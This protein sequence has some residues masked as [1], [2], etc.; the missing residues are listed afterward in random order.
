MY[1]LWMQGNKRR[2]GAQGL[3]IQVAIKWAAHTTFNLWQIRQPQTE[4]VARSAGLHWERPPMGWTK[5][6]VDGAFYEDQWQG[7]TGAYCEMMPAPLIG[8]ALSGMAT[9]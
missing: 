8:V 1:L 4:P 7:A 6:N 5:C 2:H 3:Q 9:A